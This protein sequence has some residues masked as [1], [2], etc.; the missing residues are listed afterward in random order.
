MSSF[1]TLSDQGASSNDWT[2]VV[3]GVVGGKA[4]GKSPT[5]LGN[6]VNHDRVDEAVSEATDY[7]AKFR[8]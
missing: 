4:G 1:Q 5:S 2:A 6:G 7:L 3:T 8:L